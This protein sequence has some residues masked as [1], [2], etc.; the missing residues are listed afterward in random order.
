MLLEAAGFTVVVA[1]SGID[2]RWPGGAPSDGAR[3]LA[4]A[5]AQGV[6]APGEVVVAA[7]TI[8]VLGGELLPKPIDAADAA[9]MLRLLSGKA[10]EVITGFFVRKD[11]RV[12]SGAVVTKVVFRALA[13]AEVERYVRT[14]EPL[15]KA[16]A[17]GIQG[18]G[19]GL[20]DR[21]E[22]SYTNIVGLPL[23]EVIAA[24]EAVS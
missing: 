11:T 22:G 14:G 19:G 1:P 8:V 7:D 3:A 21:V 18:E 12:Q 15:D 5:K 20:V 23:R 4:A 9:R 16:G 6:E 17:Y 24:F 10:H 13:E 2:E